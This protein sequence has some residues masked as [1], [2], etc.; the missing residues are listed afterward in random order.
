MGPINDPAQKNQ[1]SQAPNTKPSPYMEVG[2]Y[3]K[4]ETEVM[5]SGSK[6]Q[7]NEQKQNRRRIGV[8]RLS[9]ALPKEKSDTSDKSECQSIRGPYM[10]AGEY[11]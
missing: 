4:C 9:K 10:D 6:Y 2:E 7:N 11:M 8:Q 1:K 3:V 5:K